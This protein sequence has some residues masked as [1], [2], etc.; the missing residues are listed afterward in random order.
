MPGS[1]SK[2]AACEKARDDFDTRDDFYRNFYRDQPSKRA[3]RRVAHR[4]VRSKRR[5]ARRSEQNL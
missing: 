1:H 2:I 5:T 4:S 3:V